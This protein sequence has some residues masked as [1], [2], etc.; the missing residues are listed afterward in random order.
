M[1]SFNYFNYFTEI[2]EYFWRKRG[3]HLLVSP[4]DWAIVETWQKAGIPLEAVLKG[5]DRAFESLAALAPRRRR[6][7]VEEP[8]VLRGRGARR[9]RRSAGSR[10][11]HRPRGQ[12]RR[13]PQPSHFR[14]TSCA[15][16]SSAT[17]TRLAPPRKNTAPRTPR[18]RR[19]STKRAKRLDEALPLTRFA[20][21]RSTSKISSAASPCSKKNSPPRSPPMPTT[22]PARRSPRNGSLARALSSQ[23]VRRATGAA[24]APV[25][26]EAPVRA[27]RCAAAQPVL[28]HVSALPCGPAVGIFRD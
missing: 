19:A 16:T 28:S 26:P 11:R 4:L 18:S 3:A 24:R 6:P 13:N 10:S 8:G 27:F 1:D 22:N 21:L 9:G 14:A 15:N 12:S 23:N 5:I 20:R 2:E 17:P 25:H 7:P